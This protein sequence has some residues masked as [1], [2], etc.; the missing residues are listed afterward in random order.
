MKIVKK[1]LIVLAIIIA[2]PLI[3]A[4]FIKHDYVVEREVTINKPVN[5]VFGYVKLLKNQDNFNKWM[6]VDTNFKKDYQG[7][8]GTVGFRYGWNSKNDELGEGVQEIK[9]VVDDQQ[10]DYTIHFVR[11]FEDDADVSIATQ[12]VS[13]NQT[14][15]KWSF[16]GVN[17]YPKNFMNLFIDKMLGK[18]MAT[19]LGALKVILEK[20]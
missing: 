19:S 17:N 14:R 5:T 12:S 4:L 20:S 11:P 2:I 8:D 18:D 9:R 13:E 1:I 7:T 10:M 15:V 3:M 6:T 16:K